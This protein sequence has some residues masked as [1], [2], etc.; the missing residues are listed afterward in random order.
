M[1]N[2][3]QVSFEEA[4]REIL[5]GNEA[6]TKNL[7]KRHKTKFVSWFMKQYHLN[8]QEG[9]EVYH[10]AF[11]ILYFQIKNEKL[12]SL[13]STLETYLFGVGK[14]LMLRGQSRQRNFSDLGE[15]D[16]VMV[17]HREA[18]QE[19]LIHQKMQV[20][21]ILKQVAEPCKSILTMFYFR[22]FSLESIAERLG[23]KNSGTVK[24][25][26]SLCLKH[27]RE[28]LSAKQH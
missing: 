22:E 21:Q 7:Y 13:S 9:L 2:K 15:V 6:Y 20:R 19:E 27:V 5:R 12:T 1:N 10:Q 4:S 8:N 23:Y 28:Q 24:K 26:K 11:M 18:E 25:K 3:Q 17:D 14:K 16:L